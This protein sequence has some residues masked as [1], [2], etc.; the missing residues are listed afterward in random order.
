MQY[1]FRLEKINRS[2][3]IRFIEKLKESRLSTKYPVNS[4]S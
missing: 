2:A 1:C 4:K 3:W